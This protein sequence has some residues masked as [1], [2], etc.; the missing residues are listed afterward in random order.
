MIMKFRRILSAIR[1]SEL[2]PINSP[3]N[4]SNVSQKIYIQNPCDPSVETSN[5]CIYHQRREKS[6]IFPPFSPELFYCSTAT[7]EVRLACKTCW[8][9]R[10]AHA[11]PEKGRSLARRV[12][13]LAGRPHNASLLAH[14]RC[15]FPAP[16]FVSHPVGVTLYGEST[17]PPQSACL[18][19]CFTGVHRRLPLWANLE[20]G[21]VRDR[22]STPDL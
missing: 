8:R 7:S 9:C 21:I 13:S 14:P 4:I 16:R 1:H 22:V 11:L 15:R 6:R 18:R 5:L 17:R 12:V 3:A 19:D 2:I 20:K 10:N